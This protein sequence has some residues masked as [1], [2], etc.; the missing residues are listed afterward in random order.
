MKHW[1]ESKTIRALA[2][3][4]LLQFALLVL[5]MLQSKQLDWWVLATAAVSSAIFILKRMSEN[6]IEAPLSV[7]NKGQD[8]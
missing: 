5:P 6:D 8:R 7:L 1:T 3:Q 2:S 4:F